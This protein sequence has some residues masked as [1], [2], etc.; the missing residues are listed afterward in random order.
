LSNRS[1]TVAPFMTA[2][3]ADD[4]DFCAVSPMK[5]MG[6][7]EWLWSQENE[8]LKPSFKAVADLFSK[9]PGALPSDLVHEDDAMA[10]AREVLSRFERRGVTGF[11]LCINGV[12]DYPAG[13]REAAHPL[14]MLYYQGE[15][16]LLYSPRRV[17][18]VGTRD[19]SEEGVRR[20]RKLVSMLVKEGVTIVSGLAKGVDTAAHEAAI[21]AGGETIAV[22]GTPLDHA[23]PKENSELQQKIAR[24][25][26]L[27][28]QVPVLLYASRSWQWNRL[29]FPE[30]N[31]TMSALTQATV[32]VE[33]GETSGTLIQARAALAQGRKLFILESNFNKPG[34]KW[35][36]R[37]AEQ[38]AVRVRD[39]DDIR[40]EL[41]REASGD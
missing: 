18:I 14:E 1:D 28:S 13:L 27:V 23:Y 26:L 25:Y 41:F 11:G 32:I 30:R 3:F 4:L 20:T 6:A 38:G 39:F 5:E 37:F 7:Y 2:A 12:G 31:V 34:L 9:N 8:R 15:W 19:P 16:D 10:C 17:A 24:D 33:A 40:A 29:F 36:H 22:I 21:G 35:P